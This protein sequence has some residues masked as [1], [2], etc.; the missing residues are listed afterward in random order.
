[1][2][3]IVELNPTKDGDLA[4]MICPCKPEGTPYMVTV[5]AGDNPIIASLLCPECETNFPVINGIVQPKE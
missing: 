2:G 1:M 4:F 3:E 5:V